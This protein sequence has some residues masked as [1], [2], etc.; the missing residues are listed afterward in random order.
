M[1]WSRLGYDPESRRRSVEAVVGRVD[2]V[3]SKRFGGIEFRM[4]VSYRL[5]ESG[6]RLHPVERV[7]SVEFTPDKGGTFEALASL[8]PQTRQLCRSGCKMLKVD[9]S[10]SYYVYFYAVGRAPKQQMD[11]ASAIGAQVL[12]KTP[13]QWI[14][15]VLVSFQSP[16]TTTRI[17]EAI[18]FDQLK[19]DTLTLTA[20]DPKD[21][22]DNNY[23]LDWESD[24]APVVK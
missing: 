7:D 9:D 20:F 10:S 4:Q 8:L 5:D 18:A 21:F 11:A 19:V 23:G 6:S 17:D 22:R 2:D 24:W 15:C 13:L 1:I 3:Y 16:H 12:A 14:P